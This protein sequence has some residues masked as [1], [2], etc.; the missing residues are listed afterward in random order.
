M[1]GLNFQLRG[2]VSFIDIDHKLAFAFLT[3]SLTFLGPST[4]AVSLAKPSSA[5]SIIKMAF[6]ELPSS[7]TTC[8][9]IR[10]QYPNGV[11]FSKQIKKNIPRKQQ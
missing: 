3:L 11:A 6:F 1:G 9:E 7:T 2:S 4:A 10:A 8:I 5:A